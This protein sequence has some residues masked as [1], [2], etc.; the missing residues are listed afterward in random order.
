MS[1]ATIPVELTRV[2]GVEPDANS[3]RACERVAV[4]DACY[5]A[6]EGRGLVATRIGAEAMRRPGQQSLDREAG[7]NYSHC[8]QATQHHSIHRA[9]H[10]PAYTR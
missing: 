10:P 3:A 1:G 4:M 6:F 5:L 7:H 2:D 9:N 8:P